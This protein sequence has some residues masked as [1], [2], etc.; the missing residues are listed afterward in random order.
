MNMLFQLP[1]DILFHEI[2]QYL[3]IHDI[4]KLDEALLYNHCRKLFFTTKEGMHLFCNNSLT[5][6]LT[7]FTSQFKFNINFPMIW[8]GFTVKINGKMCDLKNCC[9][10]KCR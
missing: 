9:C 10:F 6:V 5:D 1:S 7:L 3:T 4:I 8:K 2:I